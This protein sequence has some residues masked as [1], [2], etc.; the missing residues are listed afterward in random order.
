MAKLKAEIFASQNK[1]MKGGELRRLRVAAGLSVRQL[2]ERFD[3]YRQRIV[4]MEK[5]HFFELHPARMVDLLSALGAGS[6]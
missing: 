4:R 1:C 6:L 2:A 5:T 3:T